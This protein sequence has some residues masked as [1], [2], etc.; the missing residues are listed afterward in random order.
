MTSPGPAGAATRERCQRPGEKLLLRAPGV[1]VVSRPGPDHRRNHNDQSVFACRTRTG[2]RQLLNRPKV[3]DAVPLAANRRW[4]TYR[5]LTLIPADDASDFDDLIVRDLTKHEIFVAFYL[6]ANVGRVVISR[7]G[8]VAYTRIPNPAAQIPTAVVACLMPACYN[9]DNEVTHDVL[10]DSGDIPV[11]SL[12][13]TGNVLSW[14]NA[15]ALRTAPF[16]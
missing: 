16:D 4:I 12:R 15:G 10:L 13:L 3:T 1:V 11:S 6:G 2:T 8:S 9:R 7:S 14:L 5:L